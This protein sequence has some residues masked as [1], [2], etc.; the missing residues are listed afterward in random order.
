MNKILIIALLTI[1]L[2][3]NLLAMTQEN[4]IQCEKIIADLTANRNLFEQLNNN[5]N[6][7]TNITKI[8]RNENYNNNEIITLLESI[9]EKLITTYKN[10][11]DQRELDQAKIKEIFINIQRLTREE[12]TIL[13]EKGKNISMRIEQQN[14]Q[15]LAK[16]QRKTSSSTMVPVATP[17]H[18]SSI[19]PKLM[20]TIKGRKR[21]KYVSVQDQIK[22]QRLEVQ[23]FQDQSPTKFK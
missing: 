9:K 20:T 22:R 5:N 3:C 14:E 21:H 15:E 7:A 8:L 10:T 19:K 16:N 17:I 18:N 2:P 12:M 1:I 6:H 13:A 23:R 11:G 4:K